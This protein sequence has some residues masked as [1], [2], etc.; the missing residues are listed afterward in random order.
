M[1]NEIRVTSSIQVNNA[2]LKY[3]SK[4]TSFLADQATAKGMSPGL[5]DATTAGT[6]VSFSGLTTPG[7]CEIINLDPTNYVQYG[8]SDGSYFYP[9]GEVLPNESYTIRLYRSLGRREAIPGTGSSSPL[10]FMVRADTA[11]CNVIV[12][13]FDK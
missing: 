5:I 2:N 6:V 3:A 9:L 13:G 10:S 11:A 8:L 1:A 4:N 12:N 7:L